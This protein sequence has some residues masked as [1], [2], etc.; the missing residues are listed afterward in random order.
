MKLEF[1]NTRLTWARSI[2][3]Y[4]KVQAFIGFLI[5][6]NRT[7]ISPEATQSELL[8]IGCGSNIVNGFIN[9]DY[10][11]RPGIHICWDLKNGIPL[12][13]R[14]MVGAF[15]EHCLEH[16]SLANCK[17]V[18]GELHRVLRPGGRVR[19]VVP[20]AELYLNEYTRSRADGQFNAPYFDVNTDEKTP[21]MAINRVFRNF[22][23][24]YAYDF[25]TM[26]V[27]L[28]EVGFYDIVHCA[29]MR[30]ADARLLIDS[31][32][33]AVESLYVEATRP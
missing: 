7:F 17:H 10:S 22:G 13:D 4:S 11:W 2:W 18:L 6:N 19:I 30:G 1:S 14:S 32:D 5:R 9:L 23:H 27:L 24:E 29:Y 25:E 33:R 31:I 3:S 15:S 21:L 8:N 12:P 26:Q 16:L 20:D 28:A